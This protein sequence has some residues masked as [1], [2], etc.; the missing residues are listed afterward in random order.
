MGLWLLCHLVLIAV[1][2][3]QIENTTTQSEANFTQVALAD[4]NTNITDTTTDH[5]TDTTTDHT[6]GTTTSHDVGMDQGDS[7]KADNLAD[8]LTKKIGE[9]VTEIVGTGGDTQTTVATPSTED[10]TAST[11][12][13][14]NCSVPVLLDHYCDDVP[15]DVNEFFKYNLSLPG[16]LASIFRQDI[17]DALQNCTPGSWCLP[18]IYHADVRNSKSRFYVESPFC[19][20]A[21]W[22]CL[23]KL[24]DKR[25]NCNDQLLEYLV[26][27][28]ILLCDLEGLGGLG[29]ECYARIVESLYVAYVHLINSIASNKSTP[30]PDTYKLKETANP[31]QADCTGYKVQM[32]ITYLCADDGCNY[33][34]NMLLEESQPLAPFAREAANLARRCN[35]SATCQSDYDSDDTEFPF[36]YYDIYPS[37]YDYSDDSDEY[38]SEY[39]G[40]DGESS[41]DKTTQDENEVTN[42]DIQQ[43]EKVNEIIPEKSEATQENYDSDE[44]QEIVDDEGHQTGEETGLNAGSNDGYDRDDRS[45]ML[46]LIV[47]T[48][49]MLV[50][51]VGLAYIVYRRFQRSKNY[52]WGYAQLI[53]PDQKLMQN[54]YN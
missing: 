39:Y 51:F 24:Q 19:S 8:Y 47:M 5:T 52:K 40:G 11:E 29:Q 22:S 34:Q 50:G 41:E 43:L 46:G 17:V 4:L 32:T 36:S 18:D 2:R 21:M 20:D 44:K 42:S 35:I 53:T 10:A 16:V 38:D 49:A 45:M 28:V 25:T 7:G 23:R 13:L 37:N 15:N 54:D 27:T 6:T 30:S 33:D 31:A 48:A 26:N 12:D 9:F 14:S 3:C 1:A